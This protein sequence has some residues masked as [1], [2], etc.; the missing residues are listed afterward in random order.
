MVLG[1]E[2]PVASID[3]WQQFVGLLRHGE[4]HVVDGAGHLPWYD[5]PAGV[6][7][8]IRAFLS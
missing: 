6:G 1:T 3:L 5:D 4:L 8:R 2:E 7:G